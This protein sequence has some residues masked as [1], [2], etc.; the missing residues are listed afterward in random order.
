MNPRHR[1]RTCGAARRRCSKSAACV[2][3]AAAAATYVPRAPTA[4]ADAAAAAAAAAAAV[5]RS[6]SEAACSWSRAEA[7]WCARAGLAR[8]RRR[9][10]GARRWCRR[11]R[12][13]A[14]SRQGPGATDRSPPAYSPPLA[15]AP[16]RPSGR[17]LDQLQPPYRQTAR[18]R[19]GAAEGLP[20][21]ALSPRVRDSCAC[22]GARVQSRVGE[23]I[24][25]RAP[26][27]RIL[28]KWRPPFPQMEVLAQAGRLPASVCQEWREVQAALSGI[29]AARQVRL[30]VA[31]CGAREREA[32]GRSMLLNSRRVEVRSAP[33]WPGSHTAPRGLA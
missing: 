31:A 8:R 12:G 2:P 27:D 22:S 29:A 5:A 6:R 11:G 30:G 17:G 13:A 9:R 1:R 28:P 21:R 33:A 4:A 32:G 18:G 3:C 7:G 20:S 25:V 23:P 14:L 16:C 26:A 15:A 10:S 24:M 19:R